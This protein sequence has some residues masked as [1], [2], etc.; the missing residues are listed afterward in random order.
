[1]KP[2]FLSSEKIILPSLWQTIAWKNFQELAHNT[3][4]TFTEKESSALIIERKSHWLKFW[5][6]PIWELPRGPIGNKKN[7]EDLLQKIFSHASQKNIPLVRIYPPFG[8]E[9]FWEN[10]SS[11]FSQYKNSLAPEIFPR[12]TLM[13]DISMDEEKILAQMKPKGR[14]NIKLARKK[15]IKIFVEDSLENFWN[16]L[17]QTTKR[18]G[19]TANKKYVY[20]AMLDSFGE[21][22]VLLSAKDETGEILASKIFLASGDTALYYYGTSSNQK[23]NLMAPYLL[24][25]EGILWAK[26][27]GAKIY[28]FLGICPEGDKNHQ[29]SSVAQFKHK[30]G[31]QRVIC[32]TGIDF[33]IS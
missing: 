29:L 6:P 1:M 31:G 18:D 16:L 20:Q 15:G 22:A 23:R 27:K 3:T 7:F 28:D 24:Q 25:W 19:F 5:Q 11:L 33:H 32:D 10:F 21:N 8:E 12:H 13:L 30:F 17:E 2:F 26:A 4:Y 14:Y 9:I